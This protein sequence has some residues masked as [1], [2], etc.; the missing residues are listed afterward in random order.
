MTAPRSDGLDAAERDMLVRAAVLAPSMHNTQ[1]WRFR[2]RGYTVEVHTDP[3]YELPVED[4]E[5]RMLLI[6]SGAA[7][8]NFRVAAA[9]LGYDA[10]VALHDATDRTLVAEVQL[11]SLSHGGRAALADLYPYL[12]RRRTSRAPFTAEPVPLAV[13]MTL[14]AAAADENAMLEWVV[15][16]DRRDWLLRLTAEANLAEGT[17]PERTAERR[18]W[19]GGTR[20]REGVPSASLGPRPRRP[21]APVRDLAADQSDHQ[22]ATDSFEAEAA[23]GVLATRYDTPRSWL[24]AGQALERVLLVATRHGVSASLL[25]QAVEHAELRWLIRDPLTGWS[26][27]QAVLRFGYGPAAPPTPRR[28]IEE[29]VDD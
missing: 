14:V 10:A 18:Q 19:V 9:R 6:G 16:P 1:P 25:N 29:F 11:G 2:F 21:S 26:E 3:R 12:A 20:D 28:P 5:R 7:V 8:F 4:P 15:E 17:D 24:V 23:L 27:P 13:R 22:R